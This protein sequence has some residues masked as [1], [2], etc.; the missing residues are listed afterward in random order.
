M[1]NKSQ[2]S[3]TPTGIYKI[4]NMVCSALGRKPTSFKIIKCYHQGR[5][6]QVPN[7]VVWDT[8]SLSVLQCH[9][10]MKNLEKHS[11]NSPCDILILIEGRPRNL[12]GGKKANKIRDT[13]FVFKNF[14]MQIQEFSEY[15]RSFYSLSGSHWFHIG[16]KSCSCPPTLSYLFCIKENIDQEGKS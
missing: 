14:S 16:N 2:V 13:C 3:L 12:D 9:T 8:K 1:K 7:K 10:N 5:S 4:N 6:M 11:P 15:L